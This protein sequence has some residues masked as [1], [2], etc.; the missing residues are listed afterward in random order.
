MTDAGQVSGAV[1]AALVSCSTSAV[2]ECPD[3]NDPLT[4]ELTDLRLFADPFEAFTGAPDIDGWKANFVRKGEDVAIQREADGTIR[5]L[6]GPGQRKYRNFKGLLVSE[7]FANLER[8][9]SAQRHRT[10]RLVDPDTGSLK[11]FLPVAAEIRWDDGTSEPLTYD[12]V[13]AILN[14]PKSNCE[15][16][17]STAVPASAR[18]I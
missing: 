4:S 8:L 17:S 12:R 2:R 6:V 1:S 3:M 16:S 11:E 7:A 14:G 5:T 13:L 15:S 18:A 9:A 10:A